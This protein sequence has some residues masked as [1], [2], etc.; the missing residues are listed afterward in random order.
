MEMS[1]WAGYQIDN[2]LF[3]GYDVRTVVGEFGILKS[4]K[5]NVREIYLALSN[6]Y[7]LLMDSW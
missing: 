4:N 7:S 1:F 6:H 3:Y 2:L 5:S